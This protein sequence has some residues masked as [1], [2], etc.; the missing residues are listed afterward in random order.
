MACPTRIT[1]FATPYLTKDRFLEMA[2]YAQDLWTVNR[3]TLN[4]GLRYD[5][6]YGWV[7]DQ[8]VPAGRFGPAR[9]FD[10]V[11]SVPAWHDLNPRLGVSYDLFGNGRTALKASL[12]RYVEVIGTGIAERQQPDQ[13][14]GQQRQPHLG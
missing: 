10:R 6:F 9:S 3:V 14:V 13:H 2:L 1:Q 7:A 8:Q 5:Y 4:Y 12:G 11:G